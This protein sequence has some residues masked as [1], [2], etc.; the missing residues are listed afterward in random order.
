MPRSI[1]ISLSF[2]LLLASCA[3]KDQ[4][5]ATAQRATVQMRDGTSASGTVVASSAS[6]IKLAEENGVTRTIPMAQVRSIEYADTPATPAAAP[7][8]P[9]PSPAAPPSAAAST[10]APAPAET[11][12]VQPE[13][14]PP[15]PLHDQHY[16][17]AESAVTTRTFVVRAGTQIAVRTEETIDSAKAAEGQTFAAEV[18]RDVRDAAGDV[19][20]PRGANARI[21]IRSASKGGKIRGASDLVLDLASVSIGG[22][23]YGL[24]TADLAQRGREGIGAN[25]RTGMF[26]GGGAAVGAIIGAIAGGG[27]GAGIGA[28]SGAAAGAATQVITKGGSVKVPVESVLTFKLERALKVVAE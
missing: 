25:K 24:E 6:E 3:K 22:R 15:E 21:I 7:A 12:P 17:P 28:A 9:S 1:V 10:G 2:L 4:A 19:V 5:P 11:A 27:K 20:I 23:R 13:P 18:A 14:V 16:H 8:A 26:A